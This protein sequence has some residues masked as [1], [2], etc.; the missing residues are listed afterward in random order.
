MDGC[1]WN[2]AVWEG[3]SYYRSDYCGPAEEEEVPVE[4]GGFAEGETAG[5]CGEGA[6]I[7]KLELDFL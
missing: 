4:T 5:L 7:L 2:E 3:N 1:L 6:Q